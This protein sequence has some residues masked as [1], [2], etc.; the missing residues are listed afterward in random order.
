MYFHAL[1]FK[2]MFF[3]KFNYFNKHFK[4]YRHKNNSFFEIICNV[5]DLSLCDH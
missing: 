3:A 4:M 2:C 5:P 1:L